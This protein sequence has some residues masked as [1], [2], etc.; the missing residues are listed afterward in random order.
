MQVRVIA[1]ALRWRHCIVLDYPLRDTNID[2]ALP[3]V[4]ID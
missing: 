4:V 2:T 3:P 1:T